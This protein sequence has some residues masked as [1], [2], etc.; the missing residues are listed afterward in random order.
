[1]LAVGG[2]GV[3]PAAT[4]AARGTPRLSNPLPRPPA[5]PCHSFDVIFGETQVPGVADHAFAIIH[6]GARDLPNFL[7]LIASRFP[8]TEVDQQPFGQTRSSQTVAIQDY[9]GAID[10][11]LENGTHRAGTMR[12]ISLV[13]CLKEEKGGYFGD[14]LRTLE[15]SVWLRD[16]LPWGHESRYDDLDPAESDDGPILW[17]CPGEQVVPLQELVGGGGTAAAGETPRARKRTD[18]ERLQV[19]VRR[20]GPGPATAHATAVSLRPGRTREGQEAGCGGAA[21][22]AGTPGDPATAAAAQRATP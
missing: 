15:R 12:T 6:R 11:T 7:R 1:M 2:A 21:R 19:C 14:V 3:V 16:V 13:G 9:L 22:T 4:Y 10:R 17:A 18:V 8:K 5:P 20:R